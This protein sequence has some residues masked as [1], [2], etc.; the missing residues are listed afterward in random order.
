M[1]PIGFSLK[2]VRLYGYDAY[3]AAA[4]DSKF[5]NLAVTLFFIW[6]IAI[7]LLGYAAI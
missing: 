1:P 2:T 6:I 5:Y 3:I 7:P 4:K